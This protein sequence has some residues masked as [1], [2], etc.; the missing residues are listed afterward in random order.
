M[1]VEYGIE[2]DVDPAE[3]A[4]VFRESGL[5]RPVDDPARIA[6][7]VRT[8]NLIVC[9]RLGGRLI[10][11]ARSVTDFSFCC[12]LS[13]LAVVREQQRNGIGK[14]LIRRTREAIGEES[15]LLLLSAPEAHAYYPHIGFEK[16]ENAW[17]LHR[18]R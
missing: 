6:R 13:D 4:A 5:R 2:P 10:G 17:I 15:M 14:E 16:A 9:A 8:A 18:A 3:V 11:L 1:G 7:M 12:Y